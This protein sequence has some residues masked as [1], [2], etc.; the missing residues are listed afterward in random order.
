MKKNIVI[1]IAIVFTLITFAGAM[2]EQQIIM[3]IE[4]MNCEL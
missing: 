4:G 1:I 3:V 2:A